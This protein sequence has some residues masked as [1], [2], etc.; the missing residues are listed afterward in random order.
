M[1]ERPGL[2]W[3]GVTLRAALAP[4]FAKERDRLA[5][6]ARDGDRRTVTE[7]LAE[8]PEWAGCARPAGRGGH[9][10]LHRAGLAGRRPGRAAAG[11]PGRADAADHG[12]GTGRRHRR[13]A[14]TTIS[15]HPRARSSAGRCR[16]NRAPCSRATRT[17]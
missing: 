15:P 7:I 17:G 13:P 16:R 2:R 8:R 4:R 3:D 10:P 12:R 5:D 11:P 9:T 6:A 14:A 1:V